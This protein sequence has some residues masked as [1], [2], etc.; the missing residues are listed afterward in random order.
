MKKTASTKAIA[1]YRETMEAIDEAIAIQ[2]RR[3]NDKEAFYRRVGKEHLPFLMSMKSFLQDKDPETTGLEIIRVAQSLRRFQ[4]Q[5]YT[6]FLSSPKWLR[7]KHYLNGVAAMFII[8][9][10]SL[11]RGLATGDA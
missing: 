1:A 5:T 10:E 4:D 2:E 11:G 8:G 7:A 6:S 3:T 9:G